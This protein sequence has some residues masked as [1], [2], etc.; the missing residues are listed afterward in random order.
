MALRLTTGTP[1]LDQFEVTKKH[2]GIIFQAEIAD[3]SLQDRLMKMSRC[4]ERKPEKGFLR[5][6]NRKGLRLEDEK[7]FKA[8]RSLIEENGAEF[9]IFDPMFRY[10]GRDENKSSE[11]KGFLGR[12]DFLIQNYK[13]RSSLFTTSASQVKCHGRERNN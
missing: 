4:L 13:V 5:L 10:H 11:M 8:V 12:L 6:V 3:V 9:V 7:H 2:R 1:F